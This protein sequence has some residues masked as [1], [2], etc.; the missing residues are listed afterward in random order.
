MFVE[1][2][3]PPGQPAH[4]RFEQCDAQT[5]EALQHTSADEIHRRHLDRQRERHRVAPGVSLVSL[6]E[7]VADRTGA[8]DQ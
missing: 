6:R 2:V 3:D 7:E 5:V 4:A 1:T 8:V